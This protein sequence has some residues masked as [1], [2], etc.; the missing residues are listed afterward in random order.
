MG[1]ART[2]ADPPAAASGYRDIAEI[3]LG[4]AIALWGTDRAGWMISA[5]KAAP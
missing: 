3:A 2:G 1:T 4:A 5:S